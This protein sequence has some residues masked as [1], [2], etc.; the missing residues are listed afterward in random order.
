MAFAKNFNTAQE[1]T[2]VRFRIG[3]LGRFYRNR[4]YAKAVKNTRA[5]VDRFVQKAIDYRIAV[6]NGE[7]VDEKIKQLTD[8]QYV[9][10]YELSK[11]T[12]DKTDIT[13]QLLSILLAG[14]DTTA[15]LLGLT[16]FILARRSDVWNRLRSEVLEL[17]G[18]KPSFEDLKSMTY[19]RW[20]LNESK[21][22]PIP[23]RYTFSTNQSSALRLYPIAPF[24]LRQA[25]TDTCLPVGG[26]P[27]GESPVFVPKGREVLFSL[28]AMHRDPEVYGPDAD[29]YRPERWADLRPGWAYL[30]FNGGPRVCIG[31]QFA[32]TEAGYTIVR[33]LQEFEGIESRDPYPLVEGL[34]LTLSSGNGTK[35]ALTPAQ[36]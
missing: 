21:Q 14:R 27:D 34:T 33:L 8:H 3:S 9:F 26:G 22:A 30:P 25:K 19:L 15:S 7:N 16:F 32:L 5:F 4:E 6:N 1:V 29:E 12:L 20:V 17:D 31:Q 24:N 13:D 35:V 18:R 2:A 28:H 10:S 11:Q 23:V 36:R